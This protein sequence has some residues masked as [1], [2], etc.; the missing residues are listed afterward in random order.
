VIIKK[1]DDLERKT[2]NA[3]KGGMVLVKVIINGGDLIF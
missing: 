1:L 3:T 2:N